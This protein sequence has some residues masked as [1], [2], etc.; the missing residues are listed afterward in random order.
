MENQQT[1][2]TRKKDKTSAL[3]VKVAIKLFKKQGV[4]KTTM[5]Q[6]AKEADI[7]KGTLYNHFR[8]KEAI[9]SAYMQQSIKEQYGARVM[10]FKDL[11]DTRSRMVHVI[12]ELLTGIYENQEI[13]EKYLVYHMKQMISFDS[14]K[15]PKDG[16]YQIGEAIIKLGQEDGEIRKDLPTWA[17]REFFEYIFI[18]I[19]KQQYTQPEQKID[20][21]I[22]EK[23]VDLFINGTIVQKER[24][25]QCKV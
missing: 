8:Q 23:Y 7:A 18:E 20:E 22:I 17:L 12:A 21:E 6:I 9:I 14:N 16:F 25:K 1:R 11:P 10:K 2:T 4:D 13:F 15:N 24:K 19:V 5:E 3:I